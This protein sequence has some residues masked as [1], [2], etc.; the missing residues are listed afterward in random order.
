M[1]EFISNHASQ[2]GS[3]ILGLFGGGAAGSLITLRI[4][5]GRNQVSRRGTVTDQSRSFAGGDVV[6]RDKTTT[7]NR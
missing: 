4:T 2:I 1:I 7:K 5:G 6:G 3:F